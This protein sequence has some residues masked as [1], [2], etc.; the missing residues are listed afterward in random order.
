MADEHAKAF[1]GSALRLLYVGCIQC[2]REGIYA[3]ERFSVVARGQ[4]AIRCSF[5]PHM[6]ERFDLSRMGI[7]QPS[8]CTNLSKRFHVCYDRQNVLLA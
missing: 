2:V 6:D 5:I 8:F 4:S 7:P 3:R 1:R